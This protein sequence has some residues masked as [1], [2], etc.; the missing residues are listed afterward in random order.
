MPRRFCGVNIEYTSEEPNMTQKKITQILVQKGMEQWRAKK[1]Y[2]E[3]AENPG[4]DK[5]INDLDHHHSH[6]FV[7]ACLMIGIVSGVLTSPGS[8]HRSCPPAQHCDGPPGQAPGHSG[9]ALG[10]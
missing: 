10:P 2:L 3:F 4:A 9:H 6:I 8:K 1:E 5:L 7:L